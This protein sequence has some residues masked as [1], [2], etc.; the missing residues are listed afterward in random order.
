MNIFQ[1]VG[2]RTHLRR[3]NSQ[4]RV[5]EGQYRP[6]TC[7]CTVQRFCRVKTPVK[8]TP[9]EQPYPHARSCTE[10]QSI[11]Q[12]RVGRWSRSFST[13]GRQD[14][15][16]PA[17][18]APW[19]VTTLVSSA[20]IATVWARVPVPATRRHRPS[21]GTGGGGTRRVEHAKCL[22]KMSGHRKMAGL[23]GGSERLHK[24]VQRVGPAHMRLCWLS[25]R[26][27][28]SRFIMYLLCWPS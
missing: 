12:R 21:S 2:F 8:S 26:N 16:A 27:L 13:P 14:R 17:I 19:T 23:Q 10:T 25:R 3:R 24:G 1:V 5:E 4:G 20:R 9:V 7:D 22:S 6:G 11:N 15:L 18:G 28:P